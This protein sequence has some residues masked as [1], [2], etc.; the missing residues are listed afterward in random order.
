MGTITPYSTAGGRRYR[1]RWRTPERKQAEKGGFRTKR[2]AELHLAS[3]EVAKSRGEYVTASASRITVGELA[4]RWLSNKEHSLKP[5]SFHS[6]AV[7]WRV[8]GAPRWS[9]TPIGDIRPSDVEDWIRRLSTG[10]AP[11]SRTKSQAHADRVKPRG[12]TV[13]YRAVGVLAGILDGAVKD[14]R[15]AKN[16][17]RGADNL[18]RKE[19]HK[20]RR[21]LTHE[22]VADFARVVDDPTRGTLVLVLAYT[23]LRWGE[24]IGLRVRDL[25]M[26]RRRIDVNP[27]RD[28]VDGVIRVGTPKNWERRSVPFPRSS[29]RTDRAAVRGEGTGRPGVRGR[30]RRVPAAPANDAGLGLMVRS[31]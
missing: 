7:S 27:L 29:P 23:G 11:T 6:L 18:P 4:T 8:Y 10:L 16:P 15:L 1:A 13:V 2:D 28:E 24:A 19:T 30:G 31:R 14:N 20:P 5:S 21:Y 9:E 25:N 17:A 3:V 22:Q 12:A 26:L